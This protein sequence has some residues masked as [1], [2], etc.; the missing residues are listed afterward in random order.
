[1]GA[2]QCGRMDIAEKPSIIVKVWID[3]KMLNLPQEQRLPPTMAAQAPALVVIDTNVVLDLLLFEDPRSHRLRLALEARQLVWVG[4]EPMLAELAD[5]LTRPFA[6]GRATDTLA[7][8]HAMC[9]LVATPDSTSPTPPA[10]RCRDADDQ[11]FIDL[12]VSQA[13]HWL[14][15]RDLELLRLKH[16]AAMRGVR[17]LRP[18]DWQDVE[19]PCSN[20]ITADAARNPAEN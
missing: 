12:A 17:V 6:A 1:M 11:K 19:P 9:R 7:R 13:C 14:Y 18:T 20:A 8:A 10:P 16:A 2:Q 15:T 4:T 3:N 5:V